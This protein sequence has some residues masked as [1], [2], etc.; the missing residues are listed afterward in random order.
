MIVLKC[1]RI[2][3][4]D[5][6]AAFRWDS[7]GNI[8][9]ASYE[10]RRQ[11][12]EN[13]LL[14]RVQ[15]V[16]ASNSDKLVTQS[17]HPSW[18]TSN[19]KGY[20][21]IFDGS[22]SEIPDP[23]EITERFR[24]PVNNGKSW[25]SAKTNPNN[26]VQ[27]DFDVGEISIRAEPG[28]EDVVESDELNA[29]LITLRDC[30]GM[31]EP[32]P[33]YISIGGWYVQ[34]TGVFASA[35]RKRFGRV[36]SPPY[37]P[38]SI[39]DIILASHPSF[40]AGLIT[41]TV[42]SADKACVDL[43]TASAEMPETLRSLVNGIKA[44]VSAIHALKK[45]EITI[46]R[47][48]DKRKAMLQ[49]N[50]QKNLQYLEGLRGNAKTRAKKR[51]AEWQIKRAQDSY[52]RAVNNTAKEL[53]DALASVWLNFRYN[54]M[55][56]VYLMQDLTD[57]YDSYTADFRTTRKK[58]GSVQVLEHPGW[59]SLELQYLERCVIKRGLDPDLR[60]TS[61]THANFVT[62]AW[63]LVPLS[64]VVDWFVNIGDLLTSSF[65]P[66]LALSQGA[67]FSRKLDFVGSVSNKETGQSCHYNIATYRRRVIQPETMTGLSLNFE[68]SV[69][70]Q[71][72]ALALLW[73]PI[74]NSLLSTKR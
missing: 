70:R 71:L 47:S 54:I 51:Q 8:E 43:L 21:Y 31:A 39:A 17:T 19:S 34:C 55:P 44:V 35:K 64:F 14:P 52:S 45:R 28:F 59:S 73:S 5:H 13:F 68:L 42:A 41:D 74:R 56:N 15:A 65:S 58:Q 37:V 32:Y 53:A 49:R 25:H 26:I 33:G 67:V 38:F 66:N 63:E 20:T 7:N 4:E 57:L 10:V 1:T 22:P 40:D 29:E 2:Q 60:F 18:D 24:V 36:Y 48:F 3:L 16:Y 62:T 50:H 11:L 30:L 69:F 27:S 12:A 9:N 46:S 72:D 6:P 23:L 61:L